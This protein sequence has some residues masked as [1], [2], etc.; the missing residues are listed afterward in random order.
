LPLSITDLNFTCKRLH[1]LSLPTPLGRT[2]M[3]QPRQ[4]SLL[5]PQ[6]LPPLTLKHLESPTLL[7]HPHEDAS[8]Q[9]TE[10]F[11]QQHSEIAYPDA[12]YYSELDLYTDRPVYHIPSGIMDVANVVIGSKSRYSRSHATAQAT[13]TKPKRPRET[14]LIYLQDEFVGEIALGVLVRFSK[15]AKA[16]YPKPAQL[17]NESEKSQDGV[18]AKVEAG[19][20]PSAEQ[21][22]AD[23]VVES[24]E[25]EAGN[26]T[27]TESPS[28]D[29]TSFELPPQKSFTISVPT[30][31]VQPSLS[32]VKHIL[33]WMQ[34]NKRT[35]NDDPLLPLTPVPLAKLSLKTLIDTFAGVL[36]YDLAPFPRDLRHEIMTR[37]T[38]NPCKVEQI[39]YLYEHLPVEDPILNRLVT[40]FFEH[41]EADH[42]TQQEINAIYGYIYEE[43]DDAGELERHFDRVK[44]S[45][46]RKQTR[47]SAMEKLREGFEDFA[48]PMAEALVADAEAAPPKNEGRR[49]DRREQQRGGKAAQA[50]AAKGK[51]KGKAS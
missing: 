33:T 11:W 10:P 50:S 39:R 1:E 49:R 23:R 26:T 15:L 35:R 22:D 4:D 9:E 3:S 45:R 37:L 19:Q 25:V 41:T 18:K 43:V 32:I 34:Q 12:R 14:V 21:S 31:W 48:G 5:K 2:F 7:G 17:N 24:H 30:A 20:A 36:A 13:P 44:R 28:E 6:S 40:S 47:V 46:A 29:A 8:P 16:T 27:T 51:G 38:Q 42:Y